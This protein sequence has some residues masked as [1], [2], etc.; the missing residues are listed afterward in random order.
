MI[1]L[2]NQLLD[3]PHLSGGWIILTRDKMLTNRDI[4]KFV[5]KILEKYAYG[6][7]LGSFVSAHE[8]WYQHFICCVYIFVQCTIHITCYEFANDAGPSTPNIHPTFIFALSN[9][10]SY[11]TKPNIISYYFFRHRFSFTLL[12]LVYETR[13][14]S[15]ILVYS[16]SLYVTV[17][18]EEKK[19]SQDTHFSK[20]KG[21][22]AYTFLPNSVG[23]VSPPQCRY[24][25]L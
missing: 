14:S 18:I 20:Y 5:N 24:S 1:M 17:N 19:L 21:L 6:K 4:N 22:P 9:H 15:G 11:I 23:V 10:L 25:R 3:V 8:T 7:F 12:R 16:S 13:L 2:F